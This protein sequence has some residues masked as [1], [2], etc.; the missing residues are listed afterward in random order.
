MQGRSWF[1]TDCP[2]PQVSSTTTLFSQIWLQDIPCMYNTL[3]IMWLAYAN[4]HCYIDESFLTK[5][6]CVMFET[7][8]R[9]T[10][11]RYKVHSP[12]IGAFFQYRSVNRSYVVVAWPCHT[13]WVTVWPH[14]TC[15]L[16]LPCHIAWDRRRSTSLC[17]IAG[18]RP[19]KM[20][21]PALCRWAEVSRPH[22]YPYFCVDNVH[23]CLLAKIL[24]MSSTC[25]DFLIGLLWFCNSKYYEFSV[26]WLSI[27]WFGTLY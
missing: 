18:P 15:A 25:D 14:E 27:S 21:S 26:L 24:R 2:C 4:Y 8:I 1:C 11:L 16:F 10:T 20:L 3:S 13:M 7:G 5:L 19:W 22:T 23:C 9:L 12:N 17:G 6:I